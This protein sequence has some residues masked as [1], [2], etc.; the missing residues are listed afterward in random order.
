MKSNQFADDRL[1]TGTREWSDHSYNIASGC[2]HGCLYCYGRARAIRFAGLTDPDDWQAERL[3]PGQV[4]RSKHGYGGVVMFPTTH[5]ITPSLLPSA[6]KTLRNLLVSGNDVLIVSKPHLKVIRRLCRELSAY[7]DRILYRFTITCGRPKLARIWEPGA[8]CPSERIAAL[9]YAYRQGFRTSVSMEPML[10]DNSRMCALV[11]RV[12]PF[13]TDTIWLGKLNGGVPKVYQARPQVKAS[14]AKIRQGQSDAHILAL[15][16]LL[17]PDP[18][19]RWKDSIK[20]VLA[21]NKIISGI[22]ARLPSQN[23]NDQ[24]SKGATGATPAPTAPPVKTASAEPSKPKPA[25]RAWI[26]MRQRFTPEQIR[27]RA[28]AAAKKAQNTMRRKIALSASR[29]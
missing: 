22:A 25:N 15:Y 26:T 10:E 6:L 9:R 28:Q 20:K 14:L 13:V 29:R 16:S 21:E 7:R 4:I 23:A 27:A 8:P 11:D 12:S 1:G 2:A 19:I 18:K 5:D 3:D 24:G 17:N